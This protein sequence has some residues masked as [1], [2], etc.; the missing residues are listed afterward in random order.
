MLQYR[1]L[2]LHSRGALTLPYSHIEAVGVAV[3]G[4][5][6]EGVLAAAHASRA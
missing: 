5:V 4:G 6:D 2:P 1:L 3:G